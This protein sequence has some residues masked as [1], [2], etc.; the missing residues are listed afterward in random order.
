MPVVSNPLAELGPTMV[1]ERILF[2]GL[3][4]GPVSLMASTAEGGVDES[5]RDEWLEKHELLVHTM[6]DAACQCHNQRF[7]K[8]TFGPS[9]SLGE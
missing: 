2:L 7:K 1:G 9:I 5:E 4:A 3:P 8:V 6:D